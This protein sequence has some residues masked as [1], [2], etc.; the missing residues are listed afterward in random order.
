MQRKR[1]KVTGYLVFE[2]CDDYEQALTLKRDAMTPPGGVLDWPGHRTKPAVLFFT[3]VEAQAA[4]DRTEHYCK[5][6]GVPQD[7]STGSLPAKKHCYIKPVA[8]HP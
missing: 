4:I 8:V 7:G 1:P 6:F 3:R 5:A 2:W